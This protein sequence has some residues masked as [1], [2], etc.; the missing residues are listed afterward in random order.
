[1]DRPALLRALRWVWLAT[2]A[3][4]TAGPARACR[5]FGPG[6]VCE[7][8][9]GEATIFRGTVVDVTLEPNPSTLNMRKADGTPMQVRGNGR[10]RV[11]FA[12][13]EMF[14]G[15]PAQERTVY[16][17]ES[18]SACG[19]AFEAGAEYVVFTYVA[20]DSPPFAEKAGEIWVDKC[21]R[22]E[23]LVTGH[24]QLNESV[25]WMRS[26]AGAAAGSEVF[27]QVRLP[28]G[29][30]EETVATRLLLDGPVRREMVSDKSG[31]YSAK[32]LPAGDY[33]LSAIVPAGFTTTAP[34]MFT[35]GEKGCVASDWYVKYQGRVSGRVL[36]VDGRP[37]ADLLMHLNVAGAERN[38]GQL[39][40]VTG[41][42]GSY[43]FEEVSPGRTWWWR[44][45][46]AR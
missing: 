18:S 11:R 46:R 20:K 39:R 37:V 32:G 16:T 8:A 40:A 44:I 14:S 45:S 12:V 28:R 22:T 31:A 42:D 2:V 34:R 19:F 43:T 35:L 9:L 3:L 21:S 27:G 13:Q 29:G 33:T 6:P 15:A 4:V 26:R 17:A 36:D 24:E 23:K 25:A 41:A 1:M 5:C 7:I 38:A 10:Y 30:A